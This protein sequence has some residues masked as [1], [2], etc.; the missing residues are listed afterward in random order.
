MV[1]MLAVVKSGS[2]R[3]NRRKHRILNKRL[4]PLW[5]FKQSGR[6]D[7]FPGEVSRLKIIA[8]HKI[9]FWSKSSTA[10]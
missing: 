2:L 8:M 10:S 4:I 6:F 5:D 7:Q 3:S 1:V 9:N